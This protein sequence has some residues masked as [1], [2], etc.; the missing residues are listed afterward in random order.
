MERPDLFVLVNYV[1]AGYLSQKVMVTFI[2]C[3]LNAWHCTECLLCGHHTNIPI[4]AREVLS[5]HVNKIESQG[6]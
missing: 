5:S 3:L 6:G 1:Y 2:L 4:L